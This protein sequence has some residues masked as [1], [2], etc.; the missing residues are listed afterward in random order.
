MF[1][2]STKPH[3]SQN[4][5]KNKPHVRKGNQTD[6]Y[7]T[8]QKGR[9]ARFWQQEAGVAQKHIESVEDGFAT[10]I[11]ATNLMMSMIRR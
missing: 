4:P 2:Q 11:M 3:Y 8:K 6:Q 7:A 5:G 1:R 9:D 10:Q